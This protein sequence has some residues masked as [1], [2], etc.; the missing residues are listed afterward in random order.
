MFQE[1]EDNFISKMY[2]GGLDII[3]WPMFNDTAWFKTL[4]NIN[5]K[6][7]MQIEKYENARTFLQNTKIIMAKLM[8]CNTLFIITIQ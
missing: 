3:P 2:K 7:D 5:N 1:G 6:L 8:V 4:S